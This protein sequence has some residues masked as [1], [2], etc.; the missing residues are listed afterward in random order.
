MADF[1]V[2]RQRM[3][4]NQ[5]RTSEV[6][7]RDVI[8][9]F[10]SLPREIFCA[11]GEKPFAYGDRE[12]MMLPGASG[13]RMMD[14]VRL[15][16]LVHA[17]PRGS[18]VKAM[19]VAVGSGYSAAILSR[20]VGSVVAV[21][22]DKALAGL[23][24]NALAAV[25]AGNVSVVEAKLTEG[26]T[27]GG[28]YEAILIDG[29]VETVPERLLSQLARGALT[30]IVRDGSVSRAMLYERI[31]GETTTWPLFDAWATPLPGFERPREFV[32]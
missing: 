9:A 2:L 11:P 32:F 7:D 4:D 24:R 17:L 3:V 20:L 22:E 26:Y 1:S 18:D 15:A 14:P 23:A 16:R 28:P 19:V 10:L 30:A 21:E 29:G 13:R 31:G 27:A 6:T 5:L 8:S 25:G 12:L